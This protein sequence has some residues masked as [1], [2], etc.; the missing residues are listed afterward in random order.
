MLFSISFELILTSVQQ[1]SRQ[2][3]ECKI[4]VLSWKKGAQRLSPPPKAYH[5]KHKQYAGVNVAEI[6]SP[7]VDAE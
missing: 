2:Q 4:C 5:Q 1:M 7:A 6:L 3:P